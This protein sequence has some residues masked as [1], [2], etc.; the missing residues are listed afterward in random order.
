MIMIL[1]AWLV[2]KQDKLLPET[3]VHFRDVDRENNLWPGSSRRYLKR[4]VDKHDKLRVSH[5]SRDTIL[6]GARDESAGVQAGRSS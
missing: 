6:I 2:R 4:V 1:A 5:Y 3:V